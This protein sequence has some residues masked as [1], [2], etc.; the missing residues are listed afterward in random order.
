MFQKVKI[1]EARYFFKTILATALSKV[2]Q[3]NCNAVDS[4]SHWWKLCAAMHLFLTLTRVLTYVE[5]WRLRCVYL[6]YQNFPKKHFDFL[7]FVKL[8]T[9]KQKRFFHQLELISLPNDL[10]ILTV[11]RIIS[12]TVNYG[13]FTF[14]SG[15]IRVYSVEQLTRLRVQTKMNFNTP[16]QSWY[17]KYTPQSELRN[18]FKFL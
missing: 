17:Y 13:D 1:L 6:C 18:K 16:P 8:V 7:T 4:T 15:Q 14:L 5:T 3:K 12:V 10:Y 9:M 11:T 2:M